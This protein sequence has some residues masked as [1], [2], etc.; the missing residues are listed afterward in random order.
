MALTS[1]DQ[2][3]KE[4]SEHHPESFIRLLFPKG[5]FRI[6][7]TKLE[8]ELAIKTRVPDR[9]IQLQTVHGKR[10]VHFE[11]QMRYRRK[12]PERMFVYAGA[13]TAKYQMPVASFLFLIKPSLQIGEVGAY[14]AE[15]FGK[16]TNEFTFPVIRLW[17]L[18]EAILSG[19]EDYRIFAPLLFEI[20]PK[21]NLTLL[22]KVRQ[23]IQLEVDARRREAL[24]SI[25]IPIASRYFSLRMIK[26][27]VSEATMTDIKWEE[28]PYIGD[29]IK[30][31][32]KEAWEEGRQEGRHEG[33]VLGMH[34]LLLDVLNSRFGNVPVKTIRAIHTVQS[35]S[36]LKTLA[37]KSL[38]A[39][40]LAEV[41]KLLPTSK[42]NG[43]RITNTR[44][45][46][47]AS[48]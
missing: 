7:A 47:R 43:R 28:L 11:F 34:E 33:G 19:N 10:L 2:I 9:V 15:L 12:I 38:K 8:K 17:K 40:S 4:R 35:P 24:Y 16:P 3:L 37:R 26:S 48:K 21:P 13:L 23:L 36:K 29:R 31:K 25:A 32:K 30:A 46:T 22:R 5:R 42:T 20:E 1:I 18:R 41:Q 44:K 27:I 14:H 6:V 45:P 39:E